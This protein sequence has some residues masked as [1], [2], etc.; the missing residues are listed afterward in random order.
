M[1]DRGA[2]GAG[3]D[4]TLAPHKVPRAVHKVDTPQDSHREAAAVPTAPGTLVL[5]LWCLR[6]HQKR[7]AFFVVVL[8]PVVAF[9]LGQASFGGLRSLP[10]IPGLPAVGGARKVANTAG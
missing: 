1:R 10:P 3:P 2:G 8:G 7:L 4:T 5:G 6:W 9:K